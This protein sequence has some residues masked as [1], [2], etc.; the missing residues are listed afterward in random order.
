[1]DNH[2]NLN[3]S[4]NELNH[5]KIS[6]NWFK[7][8]VIIKTMDF[9]KRVLFSKYPVKLRFFKNLE[10]TKNLVRQLCFYKI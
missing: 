1:M 5:L 9:L 3:L 4:L 7:F 10:E 6:A 8:I 2:R